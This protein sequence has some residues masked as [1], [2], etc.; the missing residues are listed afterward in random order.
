MLKGDKTKLGLGLTILVVIAHYYG[1]IIDENLFQLLVTF[2]GSLAGYG[3]YDKI[4]RKW[5]PRLRTD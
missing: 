2:T 3:I 4:N 5:S 1:I